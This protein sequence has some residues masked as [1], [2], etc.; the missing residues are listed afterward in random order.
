MAQ[1]FYNSYEVEYSTL[2][3]IPSVGDEVNLPFLKYKLRT[4]SFY[5][6]RITYEIYNGEHQILIWL[7]LGNYN[8]YWALKK[9]EGFFKGHIGLGEYYQ[10]LD[11]EL[12]SKWNERKW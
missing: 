2:G 3:Y 4:T 12:Q 7:M 10:K 8:Q 1:G 11:Y 6:D 5:V 9:A